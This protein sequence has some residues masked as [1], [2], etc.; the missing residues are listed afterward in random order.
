MSDI[1]LLLSFFKNY[2]VLLFLAIKIHDRLV[3]M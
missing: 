2:V 1:V 3:H